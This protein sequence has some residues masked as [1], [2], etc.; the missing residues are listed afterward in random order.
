[1]TNLPYHTLLVLNNPRFLTIEQSPNSSAPT[2]RIRANGNWS[3]E[4]LKKTK[5]MD[6]GAKINMAIHH[7][8]IIESF[9]KD[10]FNGKNKF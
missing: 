10:H 7:F 2:S 9:L 4:S 5:A 8:G 6:K 3:D 1:V